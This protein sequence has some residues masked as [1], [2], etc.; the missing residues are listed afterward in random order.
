[1]K[2]S[3][4]YLALVALLGLSSS[5]AYA[6]DF[7][8]GSVNM[9]HLGW[10]SKRANQCAQLA[11]LTQTA[12]ILLIQED[13][14]PQSV[15]PAIANFQYFKLLPPGQSS[16]KEYFGFMYRSTVLPGRASATPLTNRFA[17]PGTFARAP[18]AQL[19]QLRTAANALY[20]IWIVNVHTC[21]NCGE[22]GRRAE[23]MALAAFGNS[24]R[25]DTGNYGGTQ[26]N[27]STPVI[28]G[29][30]WNLALTTGVYA[31]QEPG[32]QNFRNTNFLPTQALLTTVTKTGQLVSNYDHLVYSTGGG[33]SNVRINPFIY[34]PPPGNPA[35]L[36]TWGSQTS[37]H[38]AIFAGITSP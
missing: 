12:D 38:I 2:K 30:D 6:Q 3:R 25:V 9:L 17:P 5:A 10:G 22:A 11:N 13:M 1:M 31:Q 14:K 15:C 18:L 7:V 20:P 33:P 23:T 19:F 16:Y 8:L 35:L 32:F 24:L 29:G 34:T 27:G 36:A 26:L 21:W 4:A 37:D 28:F